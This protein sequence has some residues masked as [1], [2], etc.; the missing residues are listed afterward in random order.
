MPDWIAHPLVPALAAPAVLGLLLTALLARG[1]GPR[2]AG[3][4]VVIAVAIVWPW[5]ASVPS[6]P[7][8]TVLDRVATFA[9]IAALIGVGVDL[10]GRVASGSAVALVSALALP[11]AVGLVDVEP[12]VA[13]RSVGALPLLLWGAV[14]AGGLLFLLRLKRVA[15]DPRSGATLTML[16]ALGLAGVAMASGVGSAALPTL[17][18][19]AALAGFLVLARPDRGPTFGTAMLLGAGTLLLGLAVEIGLFA[20]GRLVPVAV[21]LMLLVPF[22]DRAAPGAGPL[23]LSAFALLPTASAIALAW[24]VS[25]P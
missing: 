9:A 11:P 23:R 14:G 21:A 20:E 17:A 18:L 19:A 10:A 1:A 13:G 24:L 4:G 7:P 2:V 25:P 5:L 12:L 15:A 8:V 16:S 3:F 6:W 22:A